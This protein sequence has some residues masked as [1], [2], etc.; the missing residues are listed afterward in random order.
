MNIFME[1]LTG[2]ERDLYIEYSICNNTL[3]QCDTML[4]MV[5]IKYNQMCEDAELKVLQ[6][7][8]TYDDLAFLYQEAEAQASEESKGILQKALK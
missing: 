1:E 8:G 5:G 6:E 3:K 7:S 2:V 4:E